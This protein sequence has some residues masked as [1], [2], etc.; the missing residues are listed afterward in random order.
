MASKIAKVF[1]VKVG[2]ADDRTAMVVL[3]VEDNEK[4]ML[5]MPA[6][7]ANHLA[8]QLIDA[9]YGVVRKVN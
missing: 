7:Q 4:V 9:G 8:Q 5:E 3:D 2:V 1:S 6:A